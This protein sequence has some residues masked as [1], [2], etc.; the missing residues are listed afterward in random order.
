MSRSDCDA[1]DETNAERE[2]KFKQIAAKDKEIERLKSLIDLTAHNFLQLQPGIAW[3]GG[4]DNAMKAACEEIKRLREQLAKWKQTAIEDRTN[5]LMLKD[6]QKGTNLLIKK[7]A[8]VAKKDEYRLQAAK[9]L[10]LEQEA[11]DD[12]RLKVLQDYVKRLEAG[13]LE[14][15]SELI[16]HEDVIWAAGEEHEKAQAALSKIREGK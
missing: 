15:K 11:E 1:C 8:I 3:E 5:L 6:A 7:L 9:E 13:Y 4:I 16:L 14:A 12:E 10:D 2:E